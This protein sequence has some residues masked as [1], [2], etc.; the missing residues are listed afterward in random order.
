MKV[1]HLFFLLIIG[2]NSCK[3]TFPEHVNSIPL[4]S[5]P[6]L[7]TIGI[8]ENNM[9]SNNFTEAGVPYLQEKIRLAVQKEEFSKRSLRKFNRRLKVGEMKLKIIDSINFKPHYYILNFSDKVGLINQINASVNYNLKSYLESTGENEMVTSI[10][11]YF[12]PEDSVLLDEASEVYLISDKKSSYSL[13]LVYKDNSI[14]I[15]EFNEGTQFGY[16]FSSFCW[17]E[18]YRRQAEIAAFKKN[19]GSCPGDTEK[20]PEK[21]KSEDI[22]E[23]L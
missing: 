23:K 11:I 15:I 17:Q 22:F 9:L 2:L 1:Y 13:Q 19:G 14:K 10:K 7:G 16:G 12:R 3:S 5:A 21:L 18:N 20:D 8:L 6:L 4:A